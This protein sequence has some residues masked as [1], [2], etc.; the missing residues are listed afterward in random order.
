[1]NQQPNHHRQDALRG[2]KGI[3]LV[4]VLSVIIILTTVTL[5][6]QYESRVYVT[7]VTNFRDDTKAYYMCQSA[8]QFTEMLFALQSSV[9][10][11]LKKWG[12]NMNINIQLWQII[13]VDSGLA[14]AVADGAFGG[15]EQDSI[16]A[17]TG[18]FGSNEDG[19]AED[20]AS[21]MTPLTFGKTE[22]FGNFDGEFR[23]EIEDE[24]RRINLNVKTGSKKE[25]TAFQTTLEKLFEP[26]IYNPLFENPDKY[27]NYHDRQEIISALIDWI[28]ADNVRYGFQ[29]GDEASRYDFL[30][31]KYPSKDSYFDSMD[32]VQLVSGID[33]RFWRLFKDQFTVYRTDKINI[34]TCGPEV[35]RSLLMQVLDPVPDEQRLQVITDEVMNFRTTNFG[36]TSEEHFLNFLTQGPELTE[37]LGNRKS[38]KKLITIK[39]GTFRVLATGQVN[40]VTKTVNV[41]MKQNGTLLYYREE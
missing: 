18:M 22:G 34:N 13:P 17:S 37:T 38:A 11:M 8:L 10:K 30:E 36:F 41:I 31:D 27:G 5:Q 15:N 24:E 20:K 35:M 4:M 14:M 40:D 32:E 26:T 1:M 2:R 25:L 6:L 7:T 3:A 33:D 29:S 12:K 16:M 39:S 28:D 19:Q 9:D 23:A 21:D